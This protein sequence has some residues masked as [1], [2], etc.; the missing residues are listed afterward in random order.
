MAGMENEYFLG[1][2]V[3]DGERVRRFE[4]LGFKISKVNRG[5]MFH[6]T[7]PRKINSNFRSAKAQEDALKEYLRITSM[8]R[9]ELQHEIST[10]FHIKNLTNNQIHEER[11]TNHQV[12]S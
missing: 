10:W 11:K 2:G 5:P 9:D 12:D 1:W 3:E 7:H 6:F 8:T 4:I